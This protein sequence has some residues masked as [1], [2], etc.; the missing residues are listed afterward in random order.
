MKEFKLIIDGKEKVAHMITR[1]SSDELGLEYIYYYIEE[2][3]DTEG[4]QKTVLASRIKSTED[5]FDD[6][7]EIQTEEEREL[8]FKL[9]K[10][11]YKNAESLGEN[12]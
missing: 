7:T 10:D 5:G 2:N 4:T 9:F 3:G 8:A 11:T 6:I 12:E 1:I